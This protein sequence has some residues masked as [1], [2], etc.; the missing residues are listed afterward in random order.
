MHAA[1]LRYF[2]EV[3]RTGSIRRAADTLHVASSA[4]NRQIL[5]LEQEIGA[6]LFERQSSGVQLTAAGEVL[7]R[8]AKDTLGDFERM[9][10]EIAGLAGTVTGHV[11]IACLESLLVR[12][13]PGVVAELAEAHPQLKLT[14]CGIDPGRTGEEM[15]VGKN[16]FGLLFL[17]KRLRHVEVVAQF[18]TSIGAVMRPSHPLA[19]RDRV[20]FTDCAAFP[21]CMLHD[22][23]LLDL[24]MATEFAES[25]VK[26][27][28]HIV[29]NSLDFIRQIV[30]MGLGIGFSTPIGF[31]DE[32]ERGELVHVPLVE[33]LLAASEVAILVPRGQKPTL[34]ARVVM[35][36][37]RLRL[38]E[39]FARLQPRTHARRRVR[40]S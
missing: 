2:V 30:L 9:R 32:I 24:I 16:D 1:I 19:G 33:P 28:P 27:V 40:A 3:A 17:D 38:G 4:V 7:L 34:P 36:L 29:S 13:L 21:V 18:S 35:D 39:L 20:S 10:A 37:V 11:R 5:K 6:P 26:L 23:W 14:L 12:F 15:S 22:R 31:V 25:G 8:H